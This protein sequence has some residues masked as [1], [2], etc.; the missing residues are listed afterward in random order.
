MEVGVRPP[1]DLKAI[2]FDRYLIFTTILPAHND[3]FNFPGVV[4][5]RH[6][7]Y[8]GVDVCS[9]VST[10]KSQGVKIVV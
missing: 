8:E 7:R 4:T 3:D 9:T 10:G 6:A 1:V 5:G 2:T